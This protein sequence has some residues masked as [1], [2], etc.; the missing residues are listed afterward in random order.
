MIYKAINSVLYMPD[1]NR[2]FAAKNALSLPNAYY[3]G[4]QTLKLFSE[5]FIVEE[6]SKV[7]IY[8]A[9]SDYT[10]D[11]KDLSLDAI[12][13]T[14]VKICEE[15]IKDSFMERNEIVFKFIDHVEKI[16]SKLKKVLQQLSDS[17]KNAKTG[18]VIVLLLGY[19]LKKDINQS[20][21]QNPKNYEELRNRLLF[22]D[23]D[24]VIRTTEMRLSGGPVYAMSQ[25]QMIIIDK[26]NPEL[27]R[28]DLE[29]LW[30]DYLELRN[31]KE[32]SRKMGS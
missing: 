18:K 27:K 19:S 3:L 16:P 4:G 29:E 9:M 11:R 28:K 25:S 10:Y 7:L 14:A 2:R 1:G 6:R 12:Y 13:K 26:L 21:S 17:T 32:V 31:Y 5:F 24:L 30:K 15:L 20:L 23:I 8:H 22:S